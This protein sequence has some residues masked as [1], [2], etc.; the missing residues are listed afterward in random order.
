[1]VQAQRTPRGRKARP[2]RTGAF[3]PPLRKARPAR[4][5]AHPAAGV[6]EEPR[7]SG[8]VLLG[9]RPAAELGAFNKGVQ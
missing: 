7:R 1:M 8:E 4:P 5:A 3:P 6:R 9:E 2:P